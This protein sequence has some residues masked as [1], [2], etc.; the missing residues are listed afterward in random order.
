M[1]RK[2][3]HSFLALLATILATGS[4]C[5]GAQN[6][7]ITFDENDPRVAFAA[8]DIKKALAEAGYTADGG[9]L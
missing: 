1:Q 3:A 4:I 9:G 6:V 2:M 7:T 8:G 5:S